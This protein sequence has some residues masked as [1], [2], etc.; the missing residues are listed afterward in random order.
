[1]ADLLV[2]T[3][4]A[5]TGALFFF[6]FER[7]KGFDKSQASLLLLIYFI[8]GLVGAPIWTWLSHRISKHKALAVSGVV[9]AAMTMCSLLIPQGSM[10]VASLL[11]FLIGVPYAA[12]AFLLRA[13]MADIGD[14]ERLLSGV[15]RTGLL[16]AI[17]AGTVKIGSAAAVGVTFP[18][19][20]LLGFDPQGKGIDN[21]LDSLAV[22]FA[23]VPALMAIAASLLVWRFPLT[24][25]RHA[26]IRA[27]LA[28]RD[29]KEPS[30]A[31]AGPAIGSEPRLSE[32]I[33]VPARPAE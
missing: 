25:E 11:M 17:L 16:Y 32:E 2:G 4:P 6:F 20:Q 31:E 13:M 15:D 23:A 29:M 27:A 7:V 33:H 18:L 1:V 10:P 9:Y 26:E 5:I 8:G 3:G 28:A 24:P 14:E 21:G 30:L 22:L 12:G 19:L